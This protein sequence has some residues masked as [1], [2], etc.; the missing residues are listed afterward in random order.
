MSSH[1]LPLSFSLSM[2]NMY[3]PWARGGWCESGGREPE[4]EIT[5]PPCASAIVQLAARHKILFTA[6][7]EE[8][9]QQPSSPQAR[10]S[11]DL[12]TLRERPGGGSGTVIIILLLLI[13]F[14]YLYCSGSLWGIQLA[15]D[16]RL[17]VHK[18]TGRGNKDG[19]AF[20]NLASR[21]ITSLLTSYLMTD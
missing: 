21:I 6:Y 4:Q 11:A 14:P 20:I 19:L 3:L 13:H 17:L 15:G 8:K 10:N 12:A 5:A 16:N 2:M 1:S 18:R 9:L 7:T